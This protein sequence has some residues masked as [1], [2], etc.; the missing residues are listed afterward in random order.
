MCFRKLCY[1]FWY[2]TF[3]MTI[4]GRVDKLKHTE[5]EFYDIC[6]R[7]SETL[8]FAI[9]VPKIIQ[10]TRNSDNPFVYLFTFHVEFINEYGTSTQNKQ[11]LKQKMEHL[12]QCVI[13][14]PISMENDF[15]KKTFAI[16]TI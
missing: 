1:K 13:E 16:I 7:I 9:C 15:Q 6:D 8:H 5:T 11:F 3:T 10:D 14:I 12:L 2:K 4:E